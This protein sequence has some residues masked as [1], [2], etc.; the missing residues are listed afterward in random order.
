MKSFAE[1]FQIGEWWVGREHPTLI[2]AELSANHLQDLGRALNL[3][4]AAAHAGAN[5]IKLQTYTA[6]AMT[7]PIDSEVFRA[8]S[9]TAWGAQTLYE[10]YEGASTPWDWHEDIFRRARDLGLTAFSSV[11]DL[12]SLAFLDSLDVPAYKIASFEI[13]DIPLIRSVAEK[14]KP[15]ILSTGIASFSDIHRALQVCLDAGNRR[16]VLLKCTSSYPAP[17]R[18]LNL[19]TMAHMSLAFRCLTGFSDHTLDTTAS[20]G[21]TALGAV[22]IEKHLTL[23]RDAGGADSHFSVEPHEFQEMTS[24]IRALEESLGKVTYDLGP[25]AELNRKFARSLFVCSD[26]A[27][28]DTVNASNTRSIRPSDGLEPWWQEQLMG[29]RFLRDIRAG[30][31]LSWDMVNLSEISE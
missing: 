15:M 26:V 31:P 23:G 14:Q 22:M 10:L 17:R 3:V 5:A 9:G 1:E 19:R 27:Q 25:Q 4:D 6:D 24:Q 28:G 29:A 30:T 11:F 12:E 2:V 8:P 18:E 13:T 21:A 20:L 7:L 16:I